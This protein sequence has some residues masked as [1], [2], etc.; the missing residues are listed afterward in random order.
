MSA[1]TTTSDD[2]K[3]LLPAACADHNLDDKLRNLLRTSEINLT[4]VVPPHVSSPNGQQH[5]QQPSPASPGTKH[6]ITIS[7]TSS[8]TSHQSAGSGTKNCNHTPDASSTKIATDQSSNKIKKQNNKKK[9][10]DPNTTN[11]P[12]KDQTHQ[13][14]YASPADPRDNGS[15][16]RH[17]I[18][19]HLHGDSDEQ[20]CCRSAESPL[21]LHHQF[22]LPLPALFSR[23]SDDV[24]ADLSELRSS[25]VLQ[26][27]FLSK[28]IRLKK[29]QLNQSAAVVCREVEFETKKSACRRSEIRNLLQQSGRRQSSS[30][31]SGICCFCTENYE[32]KKPSLPYTRHC[33]EHILYNVNQL[34]FTACTAK[35]ASSLTQC[36]CP[37]FDIVHDEPICEY[38]MRCGADQDDGRDSGKTVRKRT[39]QMALTRPA[40]RK[41]RK[42]KGQDCITSATDPAAD[43]SNGTED[44][45]KL[46]PPPPYPTSLTDSD[47]PA[48]LDVDIP[49]LGPGDEALVASLVDDLG[50]LPLPTDHTSSAFDAEL[51]DVLN[52]M[53]ADAF[54]E[55]FAD[56]P[57]PKGS[58]PE[59]DAAIDQT[60]SKNCHLTNGE[61]AY[62]FMSHHPPLANHMNGHMTQPAVHSSAR[63]LLNSNPLPN[64]DLVNN[65]LGFLTTEQQ[66]QLNGLIDG[67]LAS[68][69]LSSP[70]LKHT[71]SGME[72]PFPESNDL[73]QQQQLMPTTFKTNNTL[74]NNQLSGVYNGS[75]VSSH[76]PVVSAPFTQFG[77]RVS[78]RSS[79]LY[80]NSSFTT[81]AGSVVI[82]GINDASIG[83]SNQFVRLSDMRLN[84]PAAASPVIQSPIKKNNC[85]PQTS[86]HSP[87]PL[88]SLA[89]AF[90]KKT[91]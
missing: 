14:I 50:P 9:K 83:R 71:T 72:L 10:K 64:D 36:S 86:C 60:F 65:I 12:V 11:A 41:K 15:I 22:N 28:W 38:H 24:D 52:K 3:L 35:S 77:S 18:G 29:K 67:A 56:H 70:T 7:I 1:I 45:D 34:L 89:A 4:R 46:L 73:S 43:Y 26:K 68:G 84:H 59:T 54:H 51:T 81:S 58:A 48:A 55:L 37:T 47:I 32:C 62:S 53:P 78:G 33:K 21:P 2:S 5:Q 87:H 61:P 20:D 39:K 79:A 80:P 19:D 23:T 91:S 69:S 49:N 75:G 42:G 16:F 74:T 82:T 27:W 40:R 85:T 31:R 44:S 90:E 66:Q 25:L 8:S 76:Q 57:I 30:I 17:R 13:L 88:P 63:P 6:T